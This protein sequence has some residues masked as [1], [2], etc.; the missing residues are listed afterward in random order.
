MPK[1]LRDV[2]LKA[3]VLVRLDALEGGRFQAAIQARLMLAGGEIDMTKRSLD[4]VATAFLKRRF[5]RVE[6]PLLSP[7]GRPSNHVTVVW[8]DP[9]GHPQ[10]GWSLGPALRGQV[11]LLLAL[12]DAPNLRSNPP[13]RMGQQ[14]LRLR[15]RPHQLARLGWLGPGWPRVV[16]KAPQLELEMTALPKQQ[17]PGWLRLQLD[18]R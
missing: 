17:Q 15:A 11:E 12:G 3:P 1:Q 5:Q 2:L 9:Q 8:L 7:D 6:R 18:V 4:A 10:G 14:Q 16:G 13:K